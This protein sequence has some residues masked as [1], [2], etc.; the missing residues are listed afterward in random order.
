MSDYLIHYGVKGMKWGVRKQYVANGQQGGSVPNSAQASQVH[1]PS[2]PA[3]P[4]ERVSR[5]KEA[6]EN[7]RRKRL[8]AEIGKADWNEGQKIVRNN[9]SSEHK[10]TIA[11][12]TK[13]LDSAKSEKEKWALY[14][15]S[16]NLF[17]TIAE[18]MVGENAS[19][20]IDFVIETLMDTPPEWYRE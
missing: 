17:M 1:G 2:T 16:M 10:Q 11:Q 4:K 5:G 7:I 3:S 6:T 19:A 15:D 8:R 9:L 14:G 12:L 13:K 20:E 18:D